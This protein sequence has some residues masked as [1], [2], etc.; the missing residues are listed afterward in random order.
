[1]VKTPNYPEND[2][3]ALALMKLQD[4]VGSE[5]RGSGAAGTSWDQLW[6]YSHCPPAGAAATRRSQKLRVK[7]GEDAAAGVK[8][9]GVVNSTGVWSGFP[10]SEVE[11]VTA[12]CQEMDSTKI[13]LVFK[14]FK[15]KFSLTRMVDE[16]LVEIKKRSINAL[17]SHKLDILIY[18]VVLRVD[19]SPGDLLYVISCF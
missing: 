17:K 8:A 18:G 4:P 3:E 15:E 10:A 1:M 6:R 2:G 12:D 13:S 5:E 9:T 16:L 11:Q 14:C 7:I 19:I